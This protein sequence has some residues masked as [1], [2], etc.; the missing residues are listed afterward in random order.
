MP[1]DM[2][3]SEPAPADPGDLPEKQTSLDRNSALLTVT[4]PGQ[5]RVLVNG[6]ATRSTGDL[7]RYVSRNLI[8]GF[9]YTYEV[10]AEVVVD[11]EPMTQTKTV[12]LRAGEKA[13]LAFDMQAAEQLETAL[14]VHVPANAKVYLAGNKTKGSGAVRT[15]RTTKLPSGQSW[16][17]YVVRVVVEEN[18]LVRSKEETITLQAGDQRELSFDF[19]IDKVAAR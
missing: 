1:G 5:A 4:V 3:P 14:T 6:V 2:M 16:S 18:G 19:D 12:Q 8:P 11:G 7:R 10:K 9:D 15:F 17:D 13:K